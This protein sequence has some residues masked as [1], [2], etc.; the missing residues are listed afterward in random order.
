MKIQLVQTKLSSS[1]MK[2][3]RDMMVFPLGI[4]AVATYVH[5]HNSGANL[6]VVDGDFTPDLEHKL[7]ADIVGIQPTILNVDTGLMQKLHDRGQKVILGGV[8][9]SQAR[10]E[11]AKLPFVDGVAMGDGELVMLELSK[12][13]PIEQIAGLETKTKKATLQR[14]LMDK[15]PIPDRSLYDLD[16]YMRNSTSFVAEHMPSRPWRRM[17]NIYSNKGC[18]WR[19]KTEGCYFCG[20]F[21][22]ALELRPPKQVWEEITSLAKNYG[23]DFIWDTSDSFTS[24]QAWI[25]EMIAT[26]PSNTPLLYIY[27]RVDE[28]NPDMLKQL[29]QLN[30]YQ[31]LTGIETGDDSIAADIN[32]GN[33]T[34]KTLVLAKNARDY[35]MLLLPSFIVGNI[36]ETAE[37]L[38][39]TYQH[40][41]RVVELNQ[42]EELSVS[43]MIP[44]P[45]SRAYRDLQQESVK[46]TGKPLDVLAKGEELQHTWFDWKCNVGFDTAVSYMFKL[47]ALTPLKSTFGSPYLQIDPRMPGWSQLSAEARHK[48]FSQNGPSVGY[49]K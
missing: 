2:N 21:Y 40:A 24:N 1:Y 5:R 47:L 29:K 3:G 7:D 6:E 49:E 16:R 43:M 34:N 42:T 18:Q 33:T 37:S 38:E 26:K 27:A 31:I 8:H 48:L 23:A 9:A 10:E 15:L 41:K 44:L 13:T 19:A 32:K 14:V 45:G 17:A 46:R 4:T 20:R 28:L 12:G 25:N 30:V 36:G 39:K 35:G 11:F 22:G